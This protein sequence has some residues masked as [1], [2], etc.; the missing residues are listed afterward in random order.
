MYLDTF[1]FNDI[2]EHEKVIDSDKI[3]KGLLLGG[4]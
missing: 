4:I 2:Q 1:H 3:R